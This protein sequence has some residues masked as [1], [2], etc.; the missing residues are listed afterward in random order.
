MT[1]LNNPLKRI[2]AWLAKHLFHPPV[3]LLCQ[4]TG[5]TQYAI[6]RYIWWVVALVLLARSGGVHWSWQAVIIIFTLG[7]T[8]S[9]GWKPD[10]PA[11][12]SGFLRAVFLLTL[13]LYLLALVAFGKGFGAAQ[14]I[15]LLFAE[16]AVTIRTI[17]PR[18]TRE[19][20]RV[21]S[22]LKSLS[23]AV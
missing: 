19:E 14:T 1:T 15:A 18:S 7:R 9:A 22:T 11:E 10:R 17:P 5:M 20:K 8:L 21:V 12:A 3:I 13:P 16:Y 6:Y 2:D 23:D 4:L